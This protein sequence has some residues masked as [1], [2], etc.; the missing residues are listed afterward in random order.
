MPGASPVSTCVAPG[1]ALSATSVPAVGEPGGVGPTARR[2]ITPVR[3]VSEGFVQ[4][5]VTDVVVVP[6][7]VRPV[8][9]P[10]GVVSGGGGTGGTAVTTRVRDA[11][12]VSP[13]P[14]A[15]TVTTR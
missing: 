7:T 13:A 14:F 8:T 1:L 5:R 10:G 12:A 3:S 6:V 9:G 11:D 2:T 4:A 15:A